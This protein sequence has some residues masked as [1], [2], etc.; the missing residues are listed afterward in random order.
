MAGG[1]VAE[2]MIGDTTDPEFRRKVFDLLQA[3]HGIVSI[4]V[5][6]AGITR[7]QLAVKMDKETG[8]ASIY[9]HRPLP[10]RRSR[11]T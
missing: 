11:S 2:G 7:D 4:C 3:K 9:P 6:A 8:K 1:A 10:A 5:P